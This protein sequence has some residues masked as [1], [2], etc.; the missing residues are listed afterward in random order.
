MTNN[1]TYFRKVQL[2]ARPLTADMTNRHQISG[3]QRYEAS[4]SSTFSFRIALYVRNDTSVTT[5][6]SK[7]WKSLSVLN[8]ISSS[9]SV[10]PTL[11]S[12]INVLAPRIADSGSD[13]MNRTDDEQPRSP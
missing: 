12:V 6:H 8:Q 9:E 2:G 13:L 4:F 10:S 3:N 5:E 11:R 7:N 1:L